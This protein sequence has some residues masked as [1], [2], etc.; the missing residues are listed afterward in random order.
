MVV[1]QEGGETM[2]NNK[3]TMKALRVNANLTQQEL[4]DAMGVSRASVIAWETGKTQ[5]STVCL[6]AFCYVIGVKVN[7]VFL[8][9][10]ST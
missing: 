5:I 6:M 3:L 8:P 9:A 4:A 10:E 1:L 2:D 7:D